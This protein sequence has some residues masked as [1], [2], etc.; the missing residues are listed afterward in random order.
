MDM[1]KNFRVL[2]LNFLLMAMP[3]ICHS[4]G[5]HSILNLKKPSICTIQD[6]REK[7]KINE[8]VNQNISIPSV[9]CDIRKNSPK[10]PLQSSMVESNS[11]LGITSPDLIN[12][13]IE[14]DI[15]NQSIGTIIG[16]NVNIFDNTIFTNVQTESNVN[17]NTVAVDAGTGTEINNPGTGTT[18]DNSTATEVKGTEGEVTAGTGTE[19]KVENSGTGTTTNNSTET[20]IGGSV[21]VKG[22]GKNNHYDK[23]VIVDTKVKNKK[24]NV[25]ANA[26]AKVHKNSGKKEV[27][28]DAKTAAH[29]NEKSKNKPLVVHPTPDGMEVYSVDA[30]GKGNDQE[31]TAGASGQVVTPNGAQV[32]AAN[33]AAGVSAT[34]NTNAQA[35]AN[36]GA[37]VNVK[38][39]IPANTGV[40]A[41]INLP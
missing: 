2:C 22:D 37:H 13:V 12:T 40:N 20:I 27:V 33:S 39:P 36:A 11:I 25:E 16:T 18:I 14:L 34:V 28:I 6:I 29:L 15:G 35:G 23:E 7:A 30:K 26:N 17:N 21:K 19:T 5:I 41:K 8:L 3:V 24:N 31:V 32:P 10:T 1:K 38:G 9:A 4:Q